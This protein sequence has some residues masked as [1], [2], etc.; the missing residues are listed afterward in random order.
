M[1]VCIYIYIYIYIQ[2]EREREEGR[3]GG[4]DIPVEANSKRARLDSAL[5]PPRPGSIVLPVRIVQY[6]I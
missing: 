6:G 3:E 5:V 4:R 1:Y 2:K